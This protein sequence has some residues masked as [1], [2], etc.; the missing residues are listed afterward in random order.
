MSEIDAASAP[1]QELIESYRAAAQRHATASASGRHRV[2]NRNFDSLA[3]LYRE[4]K[5]RG[6]PGRNAL[7]SLLRDAVSAVRMWAAAH[8]LEFAAE[9]AEPVLLALATGAPGPLRLSAEM[10]LRQ[11]QKGQ[12]KFP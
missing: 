4:L 5:S 12:L 10:T 7:R 1:I 6:D 11:W 2:A 9:E 8:S 3:T